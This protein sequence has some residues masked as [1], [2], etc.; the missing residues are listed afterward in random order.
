MNYLLLYCEI[1]CALW[2]AIFS[3]VGLALV[4][5]R[6]V[7]DFFACYRGLCGSLQSAVVWKMVYSCIF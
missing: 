2:S 1:A 7:I 5:P 3:R 4:M 6:R